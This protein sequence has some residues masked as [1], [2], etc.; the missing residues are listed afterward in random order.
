MTAFDSQS[1]SSP[2]SIQPE[3][4][5]GRPDIPLPGEGPQKLEHGYG[6]MVMQ[7]HPFIVE[8]RY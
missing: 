1:A 7:F 5:E 4:R 8:K 2:L 6:S 3:V